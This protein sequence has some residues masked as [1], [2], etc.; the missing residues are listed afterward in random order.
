[1]TARH[2]A[3]A[4]LE[5]HGLTKYFAVGTGLRPKR[6]RALHDVSIRLAKGRVVALVGESGSGKSTV[7]KVLARLVRPSSGE[8][9]LDGRNVLLAE[10]RRAS[11]SYRGRVQMIFQDPFA[12]LNPAH[13]VAYH[14][15]RPLVRH[16]KLGTR[17]ERKQRI[18]DLLREV[19][20]DPPDAFLGKHPTELSGGQRQRVAIARALAVE[21]GVLLA[22]EPTSMLDVSLR[23]G[24]LNLMLRLRDDRGVAMLYVTHDIASARYV[25]DEITVMYAGQIVES[26]PA[27]TLVRQPTHPYTQL[28][29]SAVPDANQDP[30]PLPAIRRGAP[31]LVDVPDGCS[32]AARCPHAEARCRKSPPPVLEPEPG[33]R[34]RC[35]LL[36]APP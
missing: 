12:S 24:V 34:V 19:G 6:L 36:G 11:L 32:F 30:L 17:G 23:M 27:E 1:M 26:A 33:H 5:A 8:I 9:L 28:L 4:V 25:A 7:T 13:S 22:D 29:L 15:E 10:P 16:R 2:E 20:L 18:A 14:L 3:L 31:P 21:P 35:H